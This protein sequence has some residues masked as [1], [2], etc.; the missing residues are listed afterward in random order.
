MN[1]KKVI[2]TLLTLA[3][4]FAGVILL[5]D[6][7]SLDDFLDVFYVVQF[8][9]RWSLLMDTSDSFNWF[10]NLLMIPFGFVLFFQILV[11]TVLFF[12]KEKQVVWIM[13]ST[14]M[15]VFSIFY[16]LLCVLIP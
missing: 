3:S 15:I 14:N 8:S 1:L 11:I 4:F 16:L 9:E 12:R 13:I 10:I 7:H 5:K 6:I 2:I